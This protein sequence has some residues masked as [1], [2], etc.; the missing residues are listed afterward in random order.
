MCPG[1]DTVLEQICSSGPSLQP[2]HF[3]GLYWAESVSICIFDWAVNLPSIVKIDNRS[4]N[5]EY[6]YIA[7]Y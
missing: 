2:S 4:L 7:E 3:T 5:G 6:Q 1:P